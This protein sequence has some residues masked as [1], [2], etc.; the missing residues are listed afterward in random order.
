[1]RSRNDRSVNSPQPR[2]GSKRTTRPRELAGPLPACAGLSPGPCS[3]PSSLFGPSRQ[4]RSPPNQTPNRD[5]FRVPCRR[6]PPRLAPTAPFRTSASRRASLIRGPVPPSPTTNEPASRSA[7]NFRGNLMTLQRQSPPAKVFPRPTAEQGALRPAF[8]T[9]STAGFHR[10]A[11]CPGQG[12]WC[13]RTG[14]MVLPKYREASGVR[15]Q[16]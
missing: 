14:P 4:A 8:G 5:P 1:V 11:R 2:A 13:C 16:G 6:L 3:I 10:P 9:P 15:N 7:G 12:A